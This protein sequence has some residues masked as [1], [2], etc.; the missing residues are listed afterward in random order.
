MG[1]G[2]QQEDRC[3]YKNVCR[4]DTRGWMSQEKWLET[5]LYFILQRS[6]AILKTESNNNF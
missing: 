4:I 1:H 2:A 3:D 5:S 6:Q